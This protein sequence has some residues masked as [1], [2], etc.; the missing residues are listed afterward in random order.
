M[1]TADSPPLATAV[2]PPSS[3]EPELL[4]RLG[5]RLA[6][7]RPIL[8]VSPPR[9]ASTAFAQAMQQHSSI[10]RYHH[11]PCGLFSYEDT[12]LQSVLDEL[13]ELAPGGLIKEMTFQ[14]RELAVAECFFRY[15]ATPPIFL[16]RSPLL[17]VESRV[18]MVLTDLIGDVATTEVDKKRARSAIE[19]KDYSEVD[20]LLTEDVFP[21]YR[22]GW[23]DFAAQADLCRRLGL[24]FAVVE[25]TRFRADP[26]RTL[27]HLCPRLGLEYEEGMLR[28]E[29]SSA[30]PPG[31]L[32]RHANWYARVGAS[33]GILPPRERVLDLA[34]F[35]RRFRE[36]LPQA[37]ATYELLLSEAIS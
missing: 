20:D 2:A 12:S 23:T 3:A 28:W 27:R 5:R 25:T 15:C 11:E 37:L 26:E 35:P 13:A 14:F 22:T 34:R 10:R 1:T 24:D 8:I 6:E 29:A 18:R 32:E 19:A 21:L 33:T 9:S 30:L 31:A 36:H 4:E 7:F 16:A 17:T